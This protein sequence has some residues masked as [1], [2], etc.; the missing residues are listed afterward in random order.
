MPEK[1]QSNISRLTHCDQRDS[2]T[3]QTWMFLKSAAWFTNCLLWRHEALHPWKTIHS[4]CR[5]W[6]SQ[7]TEWLISTLLT[8]FNFA[9]HEAKMLVGVL[10]F[11]ILQT[12]WTC[13]T[14]SSGH[15]LHADVLMTPAASRCQSYFT[16]CEDLGAWMTVGFIFTLRLTITIYW[17]TQ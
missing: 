16:H 1:R 6:S 8:F 15:L 5:K 7:C 14:L 13:S 4:F 3:F 11:L 12:S 9:Q 17:E 10:M 2:Y